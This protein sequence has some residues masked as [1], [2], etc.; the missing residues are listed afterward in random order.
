MLG[1]IEAI[2]VDEIENELVALP[3][4]PTER[5]TVAATEARLPGVHD[6]LHIDNSIV[7]R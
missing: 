6:V 4:T 5:E 7:M 2:G 1:Q 3:E